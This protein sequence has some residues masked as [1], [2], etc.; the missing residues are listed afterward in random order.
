MTEEQIKDAAS[1][2]VADKMKQG[3]PL[4]HC[5]TF[6]AGAKWAFEQ[7]GW[8]S[9]EDKLPIESRRYLCYVSEINDLGISY[10]Q[11]NCCYNEKHGF[12]DNVH[13]MH[14]T[15]WMPLPEP[16]KTDDK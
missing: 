3:I 1:S 15:H 11:W 8:I 13:S 7:Q 9:V 4:G 5:D 2:Y 12:T 16:P 14:V 6:K 10:F